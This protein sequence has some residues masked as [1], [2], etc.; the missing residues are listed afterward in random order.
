MCYNMDETWRCYAKWNKSV[1]K[2]EITYNS[3]YLKYPESMQSSSI[4]QS[5]P[6]LCDPMDCSKSGLPVRHQLPEFTQTHVHG[7]RDAIQPSHPLSAPSPPSFNLS[8]HQGL[9][10]WVSSS[11]QVDKVIG[12]SASAS[13]L[14][15]NIQDWSPLGRTGQISL[16][17]KGLSKVFS[18]TTVQ[19]H[20]FF[21][22]QPL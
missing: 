6:T 20:Q 11:H 9:F 19:K 1:T 3:T 15:M 2:G 8:Q 12:I 22:T 16:Q 4:S 14:P 5:C 13:V 10:Q 21:G 17:S 18:H 7:V